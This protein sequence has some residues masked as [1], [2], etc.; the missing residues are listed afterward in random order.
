MNECENLDEVCRNIDAI[1]ARI[2]KLLAERGGYVSQAA[3]FKA[4]AEEVKAP[5]RVEAVVSKVRSLADEHGA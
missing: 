1:D 4:N 3:S 5:K 2:V